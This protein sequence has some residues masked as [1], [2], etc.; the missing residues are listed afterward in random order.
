MKKMILALVAVMAVS[1]NAS[2]LQLDGERWLSKFDTYVCDGGFVAAT[3]VPAELAAHNVEFT[4]LSTDYSLDNVLITATFEENG[5]KCSYS[6]LLAANNTAWTVDLVESKALPEADCTEGKAMLDTVLEANDYKYLHG[7]AA[8]FFEFSN[9]D[10]ACAGSD[11]IG[12][13]FRVSGRVQ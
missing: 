4:K 5:V 9:S 2:D 3:E 8:I 6:S 11:K 10:V 7:A 13:R 12:M 1:A